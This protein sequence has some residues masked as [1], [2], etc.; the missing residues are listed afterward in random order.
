[1]SRSVT[2]PIK[3][4]IPQRTGTRSPPY[5]HR[6]ILKSVYDSSTRSASVYLLA[7]LLPVPDIDYFIYDEDEFIKKMDA[8]DIHSVYTDEINKF[9]SNTM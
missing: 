7:Y 3:S 6:D 1:M 4:F 5:G 8:L 2:T 9:A